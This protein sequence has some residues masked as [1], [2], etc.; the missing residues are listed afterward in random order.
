MAESRGKGFEKR[1]YNALMEVDNIS[2]DRI[3]DPMGGYLGQRN[4]CD[5]SVFHYPFKYYFECKE[6][7]G[8]TLNFKGQIT[9]NQWDGLIEKSLIYGVLGG[10]V[11]WFFDHDITTFVPIA[12]MLY[13]RSM[14]AKSLNVKDIMEDRITNIPVP[15][16][17]LRTYYR[18]SGKVFMDNIAKFA[19]DSWVKR[20]PFYE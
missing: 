3:P 14:G 12:E 11:V 8:N 1:F 20:N 2:V 16:E 5:F 18:Y 7:V 10:V 17:K 19:K 4:I 9:E 13:L 15:G 6:T